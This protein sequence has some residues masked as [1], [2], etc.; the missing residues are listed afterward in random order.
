MAIQTDPDW[1]SIASLIVAIASAAFSW[2]SSAKANKLAKEN[3]NIQ[4][5]MFELSLRQAIEN[6]N[7]KIGEIGLTMGPLKAKVDSG[8]GTEE[9]ISTLTFYHA[10]LDAAIQAMLNTYDDACSKYIDGKVDKDRFRKS[11]HIEIRNILERAELKKY[12]DPHTSRYKPIL[13]VYNEWENHE[14]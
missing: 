14:K 7:A 13:K 12:F 2:S 9:E 3:T 6:A 4:F 5:G 11:Y 8:K 1:V 10:S